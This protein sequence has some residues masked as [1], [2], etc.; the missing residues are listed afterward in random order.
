MEWEKT[1]SR[2][3]KY[4]RC[5]KIYDTKVDN[6]YVPYGE[7]FGGLNTDGPPCTL[8]G[9]TG[10]RNDKVIPEFKFEGRF[11]PKNGAELYKV[12]NGEEILVG[13]FDGREKKFTSVI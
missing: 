8:N 2:R 7:K 13:I 4:L 3:R 6:V 10:S 5:Y 1:I 11:L 12:E 9:F